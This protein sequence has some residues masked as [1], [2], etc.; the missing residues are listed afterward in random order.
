MTCGCCPLFLLFD[1]FNTC[2]INH[3][4]TNDFV[5]FGGSHES[6]TST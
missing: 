4:F 2:I 1:T 5:I 3:D 6:I